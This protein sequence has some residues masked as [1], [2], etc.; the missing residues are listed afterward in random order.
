MN[1]IDYIK[2]FKNN[3]IS[4][5]P[6]NGLDTVL[7]FQDYIGRMSLSQIVD[8][9]LTLDQSHRRY[10]LKIIFLTLSDDSALDIL[11]HCVIERKISESVE[12]VLDEQRK[13]LL[14]IEKVKNDRLKTMSANESLIIENDRLKRENKAIKEAVK[15]HCFFLKENIDNLE[16]IINY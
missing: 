3:G 11:R 10:F 5:E 6:G 13:T 4:H 7:E 2:Q 14:Q 1:L 9:Y 16:T 15:N 8:E 12:N